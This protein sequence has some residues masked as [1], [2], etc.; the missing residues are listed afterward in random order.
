MNV[1]VFEQTLDSQLQ[2]LDTTGVNNMWTEW[3]NKFLAALDEAEPKKIINLKTIEKGRNIALGCLRNYF[4]YSTNRRV[5]TDGLR[6]LT[7][8]NKILFFTES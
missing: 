3:R 7:I 1:A 2:G 6:K 4:T 8:N 5:C